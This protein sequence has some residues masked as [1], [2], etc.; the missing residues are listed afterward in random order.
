MLIRRYQDI[1]GLSRHSDTPIQIKSI[2]LAIE[3]RKGGASPLGAKRTRNSGQSGGAGIVI[4]FLRLMA[5]IAPRRL[6]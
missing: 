4:P 1:I 2:T 6:A 3:R 5:T